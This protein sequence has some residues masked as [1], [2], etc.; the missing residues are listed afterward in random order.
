MSLKYSNYLLIGII[1]S[2][3]FND[4]PHILQPNFLGGPLATQL[5]AYPLAIYIIYSLYIQC[6]TGNFLVNIDIFKKF[7]LVYLVIYL[8]SFIHGVVIYPYYNEI[9]NGPITQIEKLGKL[10]YWA[11]KYSIN[12]N[13]SFIII[14]WMTL[15]GIKTILLEF[16]YGFFSV[17]L[18]YC[19]YV[20]K[21][22]LF[23]SIL[24]RSTFITLFLVFFYSFFEIFYLS[25]NKFSTQILTFITPYI[26]VVEDIHDWYPPLLWKGQLRSIFLEPSFLGNYS[27]LVLPVLFFKL[28]SCNRRFY[29]FVYIFFVFLLFLTQSRTVMFLLIGMI[30]LF[31]GICLVSKNK[32]NIKN[33]IYLVII[34]G[35]TFM[36]AL[37][38]IN[39]FQVSGLDR[40][41][42]ITSSEYVE[43]NL[44]S[45]QQSNQRSNAARFALINSNLR[46]GKEHYILG[47]GRNLSSG[48]ITHHFTEQE[49]QI[50]EVNKWVKDQKKN[51]ILKDTLSPLNEFVGRFSETGG[52][53][54][55]VFFA[56]FL[57]LVLSLGKKIY[58]YG[59]LNMRLNCLFI[60]LV[61]SMISLCNGTI[62]LFYI[63]WIIS[64]A[65]LICLKDSKN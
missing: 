15:R 12:I 28:S 26:H 4:I 62:F 36:G 2:L 48:Y 33:G 51:G 7:A 13:Q 9:V 57:V 43:N 56:P 8:I 34:T 50:P 20:K 10:N 30:A 19:W 55:F 61:S 53:G 21:S 49:C 38:F 65:T 44:N 63:P 45:L 40:P 52:L 24:E 54:F 11:Q 47:I 42:H 17:Y 18:F 59:F 32:E 16:V 41:S 31:L 58:Q 22:S 64:A 27:V 1:V 23:M 35:I 29:M 14:S 37:Y 46:I 3:V 5:V 39:N 25:G 60:S 6:K